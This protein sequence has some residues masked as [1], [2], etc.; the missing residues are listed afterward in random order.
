VPSLA[1]Q[2]ACAQWLEAELTIIRPELVIPVGRLAI[3]CFLPSRPL[4]ELIGR[5]HDVEIAG[6]TTEVIPLPHPSGASSW[7][8]QRG[9]QDLLDRALSLIGGTLRR[10]GVARRGGRSVA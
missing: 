7:I 3:A 8:H 2:Q 5:S 6:R 10:L 4:D 9:H 1:E